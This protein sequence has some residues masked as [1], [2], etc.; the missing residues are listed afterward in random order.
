MQMPH[1][2][3]V[4][5]ACKVFGSLRAVDGISFAV[6][7]GEIFGIAGPNGSGKSTLFN[8][9]T[10]IPFPADA[11]E[12]RF[13]DTPIQ[14]KRANEICRD[15]VAR[16]FQKETAFDSLSVLDNVV[17]GAVYGAAGRGSDAD[18]RRLGRETLAFV[19]LDDEQHDRLAG[20]LSVFDKKRL[21][22]AS[23]LSTRPRLLL[24]DE[25]ASG[26]TKPEI[27]QTIELVRRINDQ[28]VTVLVIEH[29]LPLLLSLSNRLMV[30]NQG[31]KLVTGRP[32]DVMRDPRV[33]EAYLGSRGQA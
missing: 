18:V 13:A 33:V 25:P 29:V 30:L 15:G 17:L 5:G 14:S 22:L 27:E 20:E 21:M 6:E 28:G 3:K 23:A 24:I 10:S 1:I 11:G 7:E 19:G 4:E 31:Q 26:L 16:T 8:I 2:L 12:I 32:E 9:I